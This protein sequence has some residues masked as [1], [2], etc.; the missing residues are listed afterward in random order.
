LILEITILVTF[1]LGV[2]YFCYVDHLHQEAKKKLVVDCF[3]VRLEDG[4]GVFI[5]NEYI[6]PVMEVLREKGKTCDRIEDD[7]FICVDLG[8]T[9]NVDKS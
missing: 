7:K 6:V 1:I 4:E 3:V 2:A 5:P 8:V 9:I